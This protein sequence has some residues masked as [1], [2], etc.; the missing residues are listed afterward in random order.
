M[1]GIAKKLR[2]YIQF[3][4][5]LDNR[6]KWNYTANFWDFQKQNFIDVRDEVLFLDR[7]VSRFI[8]MIEESGKQ[9][10][11]KVLVVQNGG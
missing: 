11:N 6:Q 4:W 8:L 3:T 5:G 10:A 7:L 1:G 9:V 2:N